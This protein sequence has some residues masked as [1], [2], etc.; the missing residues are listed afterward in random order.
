VTVLALEPDPAHA[1]AIRHVVCHLV[2]AELTLVHSTD[3][4]LQVLR[5]G[6]PDLILL[7]PLV[8]PAD[9]TRLLACLRTLPDG[10]HVETLITPFLCATDDRPTVAPRG[11]RRWRGRDKSRPRGAADPRVFAEQLTS[12]LVRAREARQQQAERRRPPNEMGAE[13]VP[14]DDASC[15]DSETTECHDERAELPTRVV[16]DTPTDEDN[17]YRPPKAADSDEPVPHLVRPVWS[18]RRAHPRFPAGELQGLR[19]ARIKCGPHVS[20]L[21]LSAGGALLETAVPLQPESE[22]MLELVGDTRDAVVPF[23]VVR[24]QIS[25]LDGRLFYRGACAFSRPLALA[26]LLWPGFSE[27]T[28]ST[29]NHLDRFDIALKTIVD[30]Y[31]SRVDSEAGFLRSL[32]TSQVTDLV[33][34]LREVSRLRLLDPVAPAM[35]DL[36]AIVI[37]ALEQGDKNPGD[38]TLIEEQ[39][40]GALPWVT[41]RF[42]AAPTSM[43]LADTEALYFQVPT[44]G[45]HQ[46]CV[47]NVGLP[48]GSTLEDWQFRLLKATTWLAG[49][50]EAIPDADAPLKIQSAHPCESSVPTQG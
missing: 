9:E 4:A 44:A 39:L 48:Q 50:L 26:E 28:P 2:R 24:C 47:L 12:S 33:S 31:V 37:S 32:G 10:T 16:P 25:A 40:R 1:A 29:P 41:A 38:F 13:R 6:I 43:P 18:D 30:Q 35:N 21:D 15:L 23:R 34:S 42:A 45:G 49:L 11:W 7:P 27:G 17:E 36:L 22:A 8:S 20:L 14:T 5:A 3:D 19:G 46:P